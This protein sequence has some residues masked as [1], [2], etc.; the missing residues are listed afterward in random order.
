M[1]DEQKEKS[2]NR[3]SVRKEYQSVD[4]ALTSDTTEFEAHG[5][6]S[7]GGEDDI[8]NQQVEE[9]DLGIKSSDDEE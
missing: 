1:T 3:E 5:E 9:E 7:K 2:I 8:E 4:E 6:R